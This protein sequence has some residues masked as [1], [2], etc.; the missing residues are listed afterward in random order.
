MFFD[1]AVFGCR[2][3]LAVG[4]FNL[5]SVVCQGDTKNE[6]QKTKEETGK[7]EASGETLSAGIYRFEQLVQRLGK[8]GWRWRGGGGGGGA[9]KG[10]VGGG[11]WEILYYAMSG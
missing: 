3:G 5:Q 7:T 10:E 2:S 1:P 8:V 9:G 4:K 11:C 6:G